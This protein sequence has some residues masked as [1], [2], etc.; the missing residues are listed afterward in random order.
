MQE[1]CNKHD[2]CYDDCTKTRF[3]CE[4]QFAE[5]L[6]GHPFTRYMLVRTVVLNGCS[7]YLKAQEEFC[8]CITFDS[9]QNTT[10]DYLPSNN[11]SQDN[12]LTTESTI[13]ESSEET[14]NT[15][16]SSTTE[17][18]SIQDGEDYYHNEE[19]IT[20]SPTTNIDDTK[21]DNDINK[22][23]TDQNYVTN[24]NNNHLQENFATANDVY[25]LSLL[26]IQKSK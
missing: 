3:D 18:V 10:N 26:H 9:D 12:S 7:Y 23:D 2:I 25:L 5:C 8:N 21:F 17:I 15:A 19:V 13:S 14:T 6:K 22:Y 4:I 16:I 1:C 20:S 24:E 11:N